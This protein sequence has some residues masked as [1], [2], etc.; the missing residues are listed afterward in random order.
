M[1]RTLKKVMII[2]QQK[3]CLI[4]FKNFYFKNSMAHEPAYNYLFPYPISYGP[5]FL[6][7]DFNIFRLLDLIIDLNSGYIWCS[8]QSNL[9][10]PCTIL[11]FDIIS[12]LILPNLD[13]SKPYSFDFSLIIAKTE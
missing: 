13:K 10:K 8:V 5:L 3:P 1:V 4:S 7:I 12:Y 2:A 6:R 11:Y 9:K